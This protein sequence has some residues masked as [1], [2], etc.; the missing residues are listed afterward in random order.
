[1]PS[2]TNNKYTAT[3]WC[4]RVRYPHKKTIGCQEWLDKEA[5]QDAEFRKEVAPELQPERN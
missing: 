4:G 3:C 1:M 2:L 5:V